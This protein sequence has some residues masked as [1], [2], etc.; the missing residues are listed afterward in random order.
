MLL[1]FE[2]GIHAFDPAT[3]TLRRLS[4]FEPNLPSTRMNDGRCD[5]QGRFLVGGVEEIAMDPVSSV[6]RFDTDGSQTEIVDAIGCANS[7]AFSID[8]ATMYLADT[9]A[10]DILSYPYD[11]ATGQLGEAAVFATLGADEGYADGSCVDDAG[12]LWNAQYLGWCVQH[13]DA[14]GNSGMTIRVPVKNPT[15]CCFGGTDLDRLYISTGRQGLDE[16]ALEAQPL[17]GG[18]FVCRPGARG[19]PEDVFAGSAKDLA[20]A[21]S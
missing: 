9:R 3:G 12:G 2:S 13:Y 15:C 7:I 5:R 20:A 11:T 21:A 19:L 17:A 6:V 4:E 14:S 18:V 8:G 10:K 16:H 1:A